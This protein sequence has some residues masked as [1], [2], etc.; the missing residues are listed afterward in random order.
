M[1]QPIYDLEQS[2]IVGFESLSR[3][4]TKPVRAPDVW[5]REAASVGLGVPLEA[6]AARIALQ[7]FQA[8]P[9]EI[10]ISINFSPEALLSGMMERILGAAPLD[11]V[12]LEI[13]EHDSI[14]YYSSIA[15]ILHPLRKKGLRIAVDDAG[16]G[17]ASF[18]HIL[19]LAPDLIKLD[20][21]LTR[22]I[23][24]DKSRRALAAAFIHFSQETGCQIVAEGVET[25]EEL[26]TLRQLG[27]GTLQG[28]LLGRPVPLVNALELCQTPGVW[29]KTPSFERELGNL[30]EI[31][32]G[33][34]NH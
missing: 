23:D 28:Y 8:L 25:I 3:F 2:K 18:R 19:N 34:H 16:A 4:S 20:M 12:V 30:K 7:G 15:E 24:K 14:D 5:F 6:R 33:E 31:S 22:H 13:T 26:N 11:R 10:Y 17:Y 9:A 32:Y 1:Y 27:I 21:S 29:S